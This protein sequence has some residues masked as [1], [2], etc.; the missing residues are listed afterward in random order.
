MRLDVIPGNPATPANEADV[1][2]SVSTTDVR[3]R[4]DLAPYAGTIAATATLRIT[5]R[6]PADG[7]PATTADV[8]FPSVVRCL[9][10]PTFAG[11]TCSGGTT[12]N[13][14]VPGAVQE[15]KRAIW[16]LDQVRVYDGGA[17]SD[18][19]TSADNTLFETQGVFV[20]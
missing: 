8:P 4:S 6:D 7:V 20:P 13:A 12:A 11:A 18:A 15:G 14:L 19:S 3:R 9:P 17:D 16:E 5:D 2:M 1:H 10:P